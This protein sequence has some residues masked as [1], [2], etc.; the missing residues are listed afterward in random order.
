MNFF[1]RKQNF[2]GGSGQNPLPDSS[3]IR[4]VVEES[5]PTTNSEDFYKYTAIFKCSEFKHT[6]LCFK[7]KLNPQL[8]GCWNGWLVDDDDNFINLNEVRQIILGEEP[9]GVSE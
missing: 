4:P 9:D 5:L 8:F 3:Q 1:E 6:T 2:K 7:R